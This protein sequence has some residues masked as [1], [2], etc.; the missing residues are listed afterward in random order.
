M[1]GGG[2]G[3]QKNGS[4]WHTHVSD[5]CWDRDLVMAGGLRGD[6]PKWY[7]VGRPYMWGEVHVENCGRGVVGV[8]RAL[9]R[10]GKRGDCFDQQKTLVPQ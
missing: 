8:G 9:T 1:V 10:G 5:P 6:T 3:W 7:L 2:V 4:P